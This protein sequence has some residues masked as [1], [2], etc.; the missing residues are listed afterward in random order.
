MPDWL[1]IKMFAAVAVVVLILGIGIWY[2]APFRTKFEKVGNDTAVM[3]GVEND[4]T[5]VNAREI[6]PQEDF[7]NNM[8]LV[9]PTSIGLFGSLFLYFHYHEKKKKDQ[10][11]RNAT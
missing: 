3:M 10:V 1:A 8:N 11:Y 9:I 4:E 6:Y 5:M 2:V 7:N